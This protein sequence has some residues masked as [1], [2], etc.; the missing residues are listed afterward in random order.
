MM[1]WRRLGLA[2]LGMALLATLGAVALVV[3]ARTLRDDAP[4]STAAEQLERSSP[5]WKGIGEY[6]GRPA[7]TP[8]TVH[9]DE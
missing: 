5:V 2:L 8:S 3:V 1:S 7:E 4:A 9:P 6:R